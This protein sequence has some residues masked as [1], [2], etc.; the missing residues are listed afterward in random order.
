MLLDVFIVTLLLCNLEML[1]HRL[2]EREPR[3]GRLGVAAEAPQGPGVPVSFGAVPQSALGYSVVVELRRALS[4]MKDV[5]LEAD[6]SLVSL[7]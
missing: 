4:R 5:W 2:V 1:S 7:C 6:L 3:G